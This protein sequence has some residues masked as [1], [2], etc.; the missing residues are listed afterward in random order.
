MGIPR[1]TV[2]A[3][4]PGGKKLSVSAFFGPVV[5]VV[6]VRWFFAARSR[7]ILSRRGEKSMS[8]LRSIMSGITE[9]S[10]SRIFLLSSVLAV[11][12]Q[13]SGVTSSNENS[14]HIEKRWADFPNM[15]FTFDCTDRPIGFY[16]DLEFDCMIF[17]LC[18]EDGRRIPYM[19]GNETS[20]NQKF[21]VCDWNYNVDCESSP[22]W[23]YLNDLTY[24]ED[25]PKEEENEESESYGESS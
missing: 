17:H 13:L 21:R 5:L 16:A 8:A 6:V 2:R 4:I 25:P 20:F 9:S 7:S 15:T 1:K 22:D 3:P 11:L 24:R 14:H 10:I 19:C 23:Y 12:G 18:D